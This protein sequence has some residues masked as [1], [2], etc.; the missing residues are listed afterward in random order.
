MDN[1][2]GTEFDRALQIRRQECV[3]YDNELA[4]FLADLTYRFDVRDRKKRV[5]RSFDVD[6]L[7]VIIDRCLDCCKI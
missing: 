7:N 2:V 3:V 5:R 4:V 6:C 1:D